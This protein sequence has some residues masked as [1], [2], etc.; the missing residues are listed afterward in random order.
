MEVVARENYKMFAL[1]RAKI[2]AGAISYPKKVAD[3]VSREIARLAYLVQIT[4]FRSALVRE[5]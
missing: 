5:L 1:L 3:L 4:N 2:L